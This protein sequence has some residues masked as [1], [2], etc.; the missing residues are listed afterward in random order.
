LAVQSMPA[1]VR[2]T[3]VRQFAQH[4]IMS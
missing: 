3:H 1:F 2:A 4:T